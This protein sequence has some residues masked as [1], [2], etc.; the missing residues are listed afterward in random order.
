M[1]SVTTEQ[2]VEVQ[3]SNKVKQALA[4]KLKAFHANKLQADALAHANVKLKDEIERLFADNGEFAA[5]Q[6]GVKVDGF[7]VRHYSPITSRFDK[8]K[9]IANGYISMAEIEECSKPTPGRPFVKINT[10]GDDSEQS[11]SE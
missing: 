9:A 11:D 5:L 1:P 7:T 6:S 10:P 8:K 3:I 4:K 2:V